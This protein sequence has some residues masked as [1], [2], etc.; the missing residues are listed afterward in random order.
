MKQNQKKRNWWKW[1]LGILLSPF[2]LFFVLG[3][4]LYIPAVQQ[5]IVNKVTD[6]LAEQTGMDVSVGKIRLA[7][8]LDLAIHEVVAKEGTDTLADVRSMRLSVRLRP[9]FEGQVEV[10]GCEVYEA[11][12]NTCGW[13]PDVYVRGKIGQFSAAT[14]GVDL[15]KETVNLDYATLKGAD[16][17]VAMSDTAAQTPPSAPAK[18]KITAHKIELQQ[19][20]LRL[21]LPGD[22]LR[23][24]FEA[25]NM[26]LADGLI[27]LEHGDYR[28]GH[29]SLQEGGLTYLV[30]PGTGDTVRVGNTA[31][32]RN[33]TLSWTGFSPQSEGIDPNYMVLHPL[34]FE[35]KD[36]HYQDNGDAALQLCHLFAKERGGAELD[37][38]QGDL[39][40]SGGL[41]QLERMLL[42]T[43]TSRL[44]LAL[45]AGLDLLENPKAA[46]GHLLLQGELSASDIKTIGK[47]F[48]SDTL[49]E[50]WPESP[51][52][53]D[54]QAAGNTNQIKI[55]T[56][57]VE[58]D[59]LMELR[60][61]G[62]MLHPASENRVGNATLTLRTADSGW[63]QL[64][65]KLAKEL[66]VGLP[67]ALS[68]DVAAKVNGSDYSLKGLGKADGG[69]LKMEGGLNLKSERYRMA[70]EALR[71]P[72][73]QFLPDAGLGMLTAKMNVEGNGFDVRRKS[74]AMKADLSLDSLLVNDWQLGK[75]QLEAKMAEGAGTVHY[76]A[77][78]DILNGE[79]TM[80]FRLGDFMELHWMADVSELNLAKLMDRK[81]YLALGT[82]IQ[83]DAYANSQLTAYGVKGKM[84]DIRFVTAE[85]G[86]PARDFAFSFDTSSDTTLLTS[87][88]GDLDIRL[89]AAGSI[90]RLMKEITAFTT[91][92]E[93]QLVD[94]RLDQAALKDLSPIM[95]FHMN[96]GGTNPLA[97]VLREMGYSYRSMNLDLSISPQ[98]GM[99]GGLQVSSFSTGSLLLDTVTVALKQDT[100]GLVANGWV[101]NF[102]KRNKNK[103]EGFLKS[104]LLDT[105]AAVELTLRDEKGATGLH[106]GVMADLLEDAVRVRLYP[107]H[108]TLA[109][110]RFTVNKDNYIR[111]GKD[112]TLFADVNLIS[113]GGTGLRIYSQ[114]SDSLDDI[115]VSLNKL[116]LASL[117]QLLP[118]MPEMKGILGGDFHVV[119]DYRNL[120]AVA[121]LNI[122]NFFLE[123]ATLGTIGLEAAYLPQGTNEHQANVFVSTNGNEVMSLEG[124]YRTA[125]EKENFEGSADLFDFPL[126]L[127]NGFLAGTDLAMS[128]KA[129]GTLT[130]KGDMGNPKLNG[131][132]QFKKAHLYSEVYGFD[133]RMDEQ[134]V[135]LENNQLVMKDYALYSKEQGNNPL[136]LNGKLDMRNLSDVKMD[137]RMAARNF[138]LINTKKQTN[139]LVFGKVYADFD[140]TLKG[141]MQNMSVRGKLSIL[142]RTDV[143]YI[144]KDSPLTV[145]DRLHDLVQFVDFED[146]TAVEEPVVTSIGGFD[147]TLAIQISNAALFHC[148]LSEDGSN[149]VDLEGGGD[150]TLR[151]TQQG[152]MRLTGRFTANSGEM[153]YSLPVIPLKTFKLVQGSYVDFTGDVEN[154]T[155]NIAAKERVKAMVTENDQPR[156]VAFDVG[157]SITQPLDRMGLEFTIEAPEDLSVQNQLA[158]M[159]K[160]ERGKA[161]VGMLATGLYLTDETMGS[162]TS[163]FK[164]SNA[165]TAFLQSE[166][167]N[168]AGSAL[169]T[170]DLTI[171]MENNTTAT[172]G[173][174]TDYS[175]Q[176]AK[177]FWGNRISVII[178]GKVSTGE[179][180]ETT[181]ES[182]IDNIAIEYRLDKTASRYVRVFYERSFQDP[183][184]GQLTKTGAGLVLRKKSDRL[185]DLFIFRNRDSKKK[186]NKKE[187]K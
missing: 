66:P 20:H 167:Q 22:S 23:L 57:A 175:F 92:L 106:L 96:V 171:G 52:K 35:L 108:P 88:S 26:K 162:S 56:F 110:R 81:D 44:T 5:M 112:S 135:S 169:K 104:Y 100:T 140:G 42:R 60:L 122:E 138:E 7:F 12:V 120:S 2:I 21:S 119:K 82:T 118:S 55:D 25:G 27:D 149:Y 64:A 95:D 6:E 111:L 63:K 155:L 10:D 48:L 173:T 176:F 150:L 59:K 28:V 13:I 54:M 45:K 29:L 160:A 151:L 117:S 133:F 174:T 51:L 186:R 185:G 125:G 129:A 18:W 116:N 132:L 37:E 158:A 182:F 109:F 15:L 144:L 3:C 19:S 128:G 161:A 83:L 61:K 86:Y 94:K 121:A 34:G 145:D 102:T 85:K 147:M 72:L 71:F 93:Q 126:E 99:L 4:I 76:V 183:L 32:V 70:M 187:T 179:E 68:L 107:E 130:L 157:V 137:I 141:D 159:T 16:L 78:N 69:Q 153:K 46:E 165:L 80:D 41:L 1:G 148:N 143:T 103:F 154:P 180:A 90:E 163:G 31:F 181:A 75:M 134:P 98:K 142:D 38:L 97:H 67:S 24:A 77:G 40:L 166:I 105:G 49:L 101:K 114:P 30:R 14:H 58:W 131:E 91:G 79:G 152:D 84:Q 73:H 136:M 172:G 170:I 139:S 156:S 33:D 87:N 164:A 168:I 146:S 89:V 113:D 43:P 115:T 65:Q 62:E 11:K 123:G 53:L 9:L 17:W 124:I 36:I 184:E 177:R 39:L 127:L 50:V 47:G 74:M 8:P 178:G